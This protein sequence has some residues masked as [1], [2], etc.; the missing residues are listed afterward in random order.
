MLAHCAGSERYFGFIEVLFRGQRS[1]AES[2][3]PRQ[4]LERVARFGGISGAAFEA[5]LDNKALLKAIQEHARDANARYGVA[6][7][8][9]FII[10]GTKITGARP[11]DDFRKAIDA[12][13]A[14]AK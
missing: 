12:A 4:A 10:N 5:C 9:T 8:P 1:W 14:A 3:N 7:T 13:L 6:Q 2:D 11:F